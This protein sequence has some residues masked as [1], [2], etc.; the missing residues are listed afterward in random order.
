MTEK[1]FI[2]YIKKGYKGKICVKEYNCMTLDF[3]W[4]VDDTMYIGPYWYGYK[5]SDTITYCFEKDK[6]GFMYYSE[7]FES[8]W[9]NTAI[10]T[11]LSM[12]CGSSMNRRKGR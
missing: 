3:Y 2:F 5:S 9:D 7:Y 8:I 11:P 12:V 6:K 10:V 1:L 4:R